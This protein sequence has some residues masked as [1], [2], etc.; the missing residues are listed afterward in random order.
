M[1]L[2]KL[3]LIN[4]KLRFLLYCKERDIIEYLGRVL[5]FPFVFWYSLLIPA[6][7][8]IPPFVVVLFY[9]LM[10]IFLPFFY[11]SAIH[12]ELPIKESFFKFWIGHVLVVTSFIWFPI[13]STY[14]YIN[15]GKIL[16]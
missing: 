12:H 9:S 3:R 8:L 6:L 1:K 13:Y 10:S 2:L 14:Y 7:L 4:Y 11:E 15:T 5:L 16:I